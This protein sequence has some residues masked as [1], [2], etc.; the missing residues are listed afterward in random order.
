MSGSCGVPS[1]DALSI[2]VISRNTPFPLGVGDSVT[3]TASHTSRPAVMWPLAFCILPMISTSVDLA[4]MGNSS[5][6]FWMLTVT[7]SLPLRLGLNTISV[8]SPSTV[9][10]CLITGTLFALVTVVLFLL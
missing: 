6:V 2:R 10:V 5:P 1:S 3:S 7:N 4:L 8:T 9:A